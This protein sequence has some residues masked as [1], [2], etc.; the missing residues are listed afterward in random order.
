[1]DTTC[2]FQAIVD[3]NKVGQIDIIGYYDSE[4]ILRAIDLKI[5]HST[6]TINARQMGAYCVDAMSEYYKTGRVSDYYSIPIS[7]INQK[8]IKHYLKVE[9]L[10]DSQ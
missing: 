5:I 6:M 9:A 8:N 4:I 3:Y 7:V 10:N 1:M 2:A